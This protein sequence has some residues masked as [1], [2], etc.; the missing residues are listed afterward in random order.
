MNNC[1]DKFDNLDEQIVDTPNPQTLNHEKIG[2]LD[3]PRTSNEN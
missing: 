3:R 2:N 1:T